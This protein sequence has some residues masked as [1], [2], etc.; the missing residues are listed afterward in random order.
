[1][2]AGTV[3]IQR[4]C[5][6]KGITSMYND[7]AEDIK[8]WNQRPERKPFLDFLGLLAISGMLAAML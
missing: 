7:I 6:R 4:P 5:H 1:M 3:S 2:R 8:H